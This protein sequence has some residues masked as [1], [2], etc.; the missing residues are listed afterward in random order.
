[1]KR[2][3]KEWK[4]YSWKLRILWVIFGNVQNWEPASFTRSFLYETQARKVKSLF[5]EVQDFKSDFSETFKTEN[6]HF[7]LEAFYIK[8]KLEER[9]A[10]SWK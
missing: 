7:S 4:A 6:L 9:K 1:M 10:Y 8:R 5:L 3:L 2:K